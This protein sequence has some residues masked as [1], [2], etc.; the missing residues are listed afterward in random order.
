VT[1]TKIAV[2]V[3]TLR[4]RQFDTSRDNVAARKAG[5]DEVKVAHRQVERDKVV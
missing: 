3:L 1:C 5:S 4:I 2:R